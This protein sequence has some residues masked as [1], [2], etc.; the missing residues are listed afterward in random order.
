MHPEAEEDY[1]LEHIYV[2]TTGFKTSAGFRSII[3]PLTWRTDKILGCAGT[4]FG[5]S[6]HLSMSFPKS[7]H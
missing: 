3:C 2:N 5:Y 4:D 6:N 7:A 1:G